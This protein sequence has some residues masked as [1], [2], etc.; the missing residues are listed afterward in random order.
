MRIYLSGALA[1]AFACPLAGQEEASAQD[2]GGSFEGA[3]LDL[4]ELSL[5]E[6]MEVPVEVGSR[7]A[8]S[9]GRTAASVFV[10]NEPEIR[11]SGL[12]SVPE[13]LRLVPGLIIATDVPGAYAFTSRLGEWNFAGMLVLIDGQRLYNTLLEREYWQ[14]VDLPVEIIERIEVVRGPGGSR[15]GDSASNGVIN[16]VTKQAGEGT[17]GLLLTGWAGNEQYAGSYRFGHTFSDSTAFYVHGKVAE[18]DGYAP[19]QSGDRWDNNSVGIRVDSDLDEDTHLTVDG[20][21]H[22]S[23]THDNYVGFDFAAGN[24]V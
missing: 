10:L 23:Y 12:R 9:L 6:L 24:R 14:A 15:W 22:D 11:R 7:Q 2:P 21:Y 20:L 17:K 1:L 13:L 8:Q 4:S 18:R 16:I 5:E 3:D 19:Q